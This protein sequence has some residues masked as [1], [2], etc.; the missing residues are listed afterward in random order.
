MET[1]RR[2]YDEEMGWGDVIA[3]TE[4]YVIVHFDIDPWGY[5][6]IMKEAK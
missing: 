4:Q 5:Y 6:Q 1:T 3:E 2:W